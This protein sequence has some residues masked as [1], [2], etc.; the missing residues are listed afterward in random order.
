MRGYKYIFMICT[1]YSLYLQRGLLCCRA[2]SLAKPVIPLLNA[3]GTLCLINPTAITA[4]FR[5]ELHINYCKCYNIQDDYVERHRY[6]T[7]SAYCFSHHKFGANANSRYNAVCIIFR[8]SIGN[9]S[10]NLKMRIEFKKFFK[11]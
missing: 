3:S 4:T 11:C 5:A 1:S 10:F 2:T 6:L 9:I 8:N 7:F